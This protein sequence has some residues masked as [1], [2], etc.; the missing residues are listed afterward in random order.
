MTTNSEPLGCTH[1]VAL[2]KECEICAARERAV[3]IAKEPNP[4]VFPDLGPGWTP[5]NPAIEQI[6]R[7]HVEI[8][9]PISRSA[10]L[11]V[12]RR[13]RNEYFN[14]HF[15]QDPETGTWEASWSKEEALEEMDEHIEFI[16]NFPA[17]N[18]DDIPTGELFKLLLSR[19]NFDGMDE[20]TFT[21]GELR[22]AI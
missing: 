17:A 6:F 7:K 20:N 8:I 12:L 13:K 15:V 21:I 22:R 19:I 1:K 18:I 5:P 9:D 11:K 2:G 4:Q 14:E 3:Q 16:D 10:L